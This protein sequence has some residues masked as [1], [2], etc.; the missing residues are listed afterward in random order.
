[1]LSAS[2]AAGRAAVAELW[3]WCLRLLLRRAGELGSRRERCGGRRAGTHLPA[4]LGLRATAAPTREMRLRPH[5]SIWSLARTKYI[6]E[7]LVGRRRRGRRDSKESRVPVSH[8]QL[9]VLNCPRSQRTSTSTLRERKNIISNCY[10]RNSSP[11][12]PN[13][14]PARRNPPSTL[15][16]APQLPSIS[17]IKHHDDPLN[18]T[19]LQKAPP[20]SIPFL[21]RFRL[22]PQKLKRRDRRNAS[23]RRVKELQNLLQAGLEANEKRTFHRRNLQRIP[24]GPPRKNCDA[25]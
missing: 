20:E 2:M 4:G 13:S 18:L 24:K 10:E 12:A 7:A 16:D 15:V 8:V 17:S 21:F 3:E 11:N 25:P 14:L 1:M 19:L 22:E 5:F 9:D 23:V 6:Q